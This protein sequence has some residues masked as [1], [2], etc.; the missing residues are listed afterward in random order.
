MDVRLNAPKTLRENGR[1]VTR[2]RGDW[3]R[4]GR[5]VGL[6]W[7]ADGSASVPG[8]ENAEAMAGD[9]EACAVLV[10]GNVK[11]GKGI[12]RK[13]WKVGLEEW[14]GKLVRE[15]NLIWRPD[16]LSLMP[17][18]AIVGFSRVEKT[19]PEYAAWDVAAMLHTNK[20]MAAHIGSKAEQA[21]TKAA[22]GDLRIPIYNTGALWVRKNRKT[23]KLLAE[24]WTEVQAG[25]DEQHAFLRALYASPVYICTLPAGWVGIR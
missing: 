1:K 3:V 23:E 25:A 5:H 9:L 24:W 14:R 2:Q 19:R 20:A 13:Y 18:Q 8:L 7:I 11:D 22:V 15:R 6:Q 10:R 12:T 16:F 4:V 21:K 17:D